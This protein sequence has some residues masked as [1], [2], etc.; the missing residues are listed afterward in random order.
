M[1]PAIP[2]SASSEQGN[3]LITQGLG[4]IKNDFKSA[5]KAPTGASLYHMCN[6]HTEVVQALFL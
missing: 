5:F 6:C 3:E 2:K 1:F 4:R